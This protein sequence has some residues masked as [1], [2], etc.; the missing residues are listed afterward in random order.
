MMTKFLKLFAILFLAGFVF[1][2]T[3]AIAQQLGTHQYCKNVWLPVGVSCDAGFSGISIP[4]GVGAGQP[5]NRMVG[6]QQL[7]CSWK[8][9]LLEAGKGAIYGN[10]F[11]L[12]VNLL[13]G[14]EAISRDG[15]TVGGALVKATIMCDPM[16]VDDGDMNSVS[17]NR[18]NQQHQQRGGQVV[19]PG[20]CTFD[21][22]TVVSTPRGRQGC[23]EI[24]KAL[25]VRVTAA[26][27][28]Q[29]AGGLKT[30]GKV[31][32]KINGNECAV[33]N[34]DDE[35]VSDF[36]DPLKNMKEI[37]VTSGQQCREEKIAFAKS[38]GVKLKE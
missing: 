5:F 20:T 36:H 37:V 12:A 7:R 29:N 6:G 13:S 1:Q 26:G 10:V 30:F 2:T 21:D 14:K 28:P 15:A 19:V 11:A 17:I 27:V 33:F 24:K 3:P 22:G 16:A 18:Q 25:S 23:E 34:S 4:Y 9:E 35:I 8:D 38:T 32:T 31:A